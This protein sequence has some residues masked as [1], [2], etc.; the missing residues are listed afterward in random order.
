METDKNVSYR[1]TGTGSFTVILFHSWHKGGTLHIFKRL[2]ER[3]FV[4][5]LH[6]EPYRDFEVSLISSFAPSVSR[7]LLISTV[8]YFIPLKCKTH[9]KTLIPWFGRSDLLWFYARAFLLLKSQIDKQRIHLAQLQKCR[10][11][12]GKVKGERATLNLS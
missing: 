2:L 5:W 4:L 8:S 10:E 11:F 6:V 12:Q 7:K 9:F 3:S 1:L